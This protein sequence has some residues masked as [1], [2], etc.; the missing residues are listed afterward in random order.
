MGTS[1]SN[2]CGIQRDR[3]NTLERPCDYQSRP[4]S[5]A[6]RRIRAVVLCIWSF[7]LIRLPY[8]TLGDLYTPL[9]VQ[10]AGAYPTIVLLLVSSQRSL[11][12]ATQFSDVPSRPIEFDHNPALSPPT[13]LT[14]DPHSRL[15][16]R[17]P[18]D[19]CSSVNGIL[20]LSHNNPRSKT[21]PE[22]V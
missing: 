15:N 22:P 5:C 8:G 18:A 4:D 19:Q 1:A 12:D 21:N 11:T 10:I 17:I 20:D 14:N 9:N 13:T 6:S 3:Q 7:S 16:I 2:P